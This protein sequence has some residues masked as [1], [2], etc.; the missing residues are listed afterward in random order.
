MFRNEQNT[1]ALLSDHMPFIVETTQSEKILCW[2]IMKQM[3]YNDKYK[4]YNNGF[5][6]DNESDELYFARLHHEAA[7]LADAVKK[8]NPGRI[9][10]QECP[11]TDESYKQFED[12]INQH[13][14]LKQHYVIKHLVNNSCNLMTLYDARAYEIHDELTAK[15]T[16]T[17]LTEGLQNLIYPLV[18][19]N[20]ATQENTLVVNVHASFVKDIKS[21]VDVLQQS[22]LSLGIKNVVFLGDFN[23]D[24]VL[25]SDNY[26]KQDVSSSLDKNQMLANNLYVKAINSGSFCSSFSRNQQK[27]QWVETRDGSISTQPITVTSLVEVGM[28]NTALSFTKR[29]SDMLRVMP[30]DFL[31]MLHDFNQEQLKVVK[32]E[33]NFS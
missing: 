25:K 17:T 2:N 9:C 10:L 32:K 18:F 19:R 11:E 6:C 22:A 8:L 1:S 13:P 20:K 23:R 29:I 30:A 4:F 27:D 3:R 31:K 16:S 24:L 14:I 28:A 7:Q 21:D 33:C 12:A 5:N 26:S 15:I